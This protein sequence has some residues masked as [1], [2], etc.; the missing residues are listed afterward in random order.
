MCGIHGIVYKKRDP[1]AGPIKKMLLTSIHRGPDF[2]S[3][4]SFADHQFTIYL[5][6]NLLKISDLSANAHQPY[7]LH[8]ECGLT[9]N[10]QLYELPQDTETYPNDTSALY[11]WLR[12][13]GATRLGVL[14]GMFAFGFVD[15]LQHKLILARDSAGMKPLYFAE[16]DKCLIFSSE[17]KAILNSGLVDIG[18]NYRQIAHYFAYKHAQPNATFIAGIHQLPPGSYL[19][20]N[21][22]KHEVSIQQFK[23]DAAPEITPNNNQT[24]DKILDAAIQRHLKS[25]VPVG[26]M[27][28]GGIDS[29]L[30]LH[31]AAKHTPDI[32]AYVIHTN[33]ASAHAKTAIQL[34][35]GQYRPID[36]NNTTFTEAITLFPMDLP[37]AD[38]AAW[39]TYILCKAAKPESRVLLN[40]AGADEHFA[41]YR[42]HLAW[43]WYLTLR[44]FGVNKL[45]GKVLQKLS[46]K[47]ELQKLARTL[48]MPPSRAL[49]ALPMMN[50]E[51]LGL[52]KK[53]YRCVDAGTYFSNVPDFKQILA[54]DQRHY[55]PGDVLSL[56][57]QAAMANS[58][59]IR[60]PFLD[61]AVTGFADQ[62]SSSSML[63]PHA[64]KA[65]GK[66][67]LRN[68]LTQKGGAQ[69]LNAPKEGFG[70]DLR[71]WLLHPSSKPL[72]ADLQQIHP[73]LSE[74]FEPNDMSKWLQHQKQ[75]GY[76]MAQEV[77]AC[78]I[79]QRW[80]Q[81]VFN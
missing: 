5:G 21:W 44:K 36:V 50:A 37:V 14:K 35:G 73:V 65:F 49:A 34:F 6:H 75:Q 40:G 57:D 78:I 19:E 58:I 53:E 22:Q 60:L 47:D 4:I 30:L 28:S 80:L 56:A 3:Y 32:P 54:F 63:N 70:F 51:L 26:I 64:L 27:L 67:P 17:V 77:F 72:L 38:S 13:Y 46:R 7:S 33:N 59:E 42:R 45:S 43:F 9:Y 69:L 29:S 10:G 76:P 20:Y 18:I 74:I 15:V 71:S 8:A 16:N 39:L 52:C 23:V 31:F 1:G 11:H 79:M 81:K 61:S 25:A 12:R 2:K 41:G 24:P 62:L 48:Q 55:L 68:L 66:L